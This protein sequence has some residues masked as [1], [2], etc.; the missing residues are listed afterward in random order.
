VFVAAA[1]ARHFVIELGEYELEYLFEDVNACICEDFVFHIDN[2]V[3]ERTR[4]CTLPF[5]RPL[6]LNKSVNRP[7]LPRDIVDALSRRRHVGDFDKI[8]GVFSMPDDRLDAI[9][10]KRER[11]SRGMGV[12]SK[13]FLAVLRLPLL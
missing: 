4:F 1:M 13:L 5:A 11:R 9:A 3:T 12:E 2:E 6:L 8:V 10:P 7:R